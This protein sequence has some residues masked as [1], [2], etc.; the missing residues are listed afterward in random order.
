MI[1][2]VDT[3]GANLASLLNALER[4]E[5]EAK[6]TSDPEVI[7]KASHVFLPGVGA[8]GDSMERL[9]RTEL[10]SL[11]KELKQPTMGICLGMQLLFEK[12]DEGPAEC[13]GILPGT[14][15]RLPNRRGF[16]VP[17]MGWNQVEGGGRLLRDLSEES[18]FY[19]VHSYVVPDG[20]WV[21]ARFDHGGNFP[22]IVEKDNY[23]GAQFHPEK[24]AKA[25][26]ALL[27]NFI[28]L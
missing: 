15:S 5:R 28:E 26:A 6:V 18:Y 24:S 16:S 10:V 14:V 13:L 9:R 23:F 21:Q 17:H 11:L 1:A 7:L 25:G 3:G 8:A 27:R 2:I 4:L 22:A 12:S 19:F 20:D